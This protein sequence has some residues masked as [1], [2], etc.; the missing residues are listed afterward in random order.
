M[1]RLPAAIGIAAALAASAAALAASRPALAWTAFA[2]AFL[3]FGLSS[4]VSLNWQILAGTLLGIGFGHA[5]AD[6]WL[7]PETA[8]AMK[9]VGKLFIGLLKMLIA[10]MILLSISH[11]VASMEGA[12]ELGRLGSRTVLLYLATMVLAA[13]TGLVLVNAV[14]PGVGSDLANT[15][16][17]QQAV[18]SHSAPPQGPPSLGDFFFTTL[19]EVLQTPV[20]ALAEGRILPVVVFAILFGVALLQVGPSARP[21][22]DW[23]GGATAAVMKIIGWFVRLAPV[24]ILALIGHLVATVGFRVIVDNLAAF[25]AVVIGAT[26]FHSFVTLPAMCWFL[27]G[28]GPIELVRGLREALVVAFTTSSSAA[29]LPV[30][31]RCVEENLGVPRQIASFVLP[32]GATVNSDGTA[33][34]EA[35]AAVFV[36]SLYGIHLGLGGQIVVF[37]IAIAT[38]IGAPGIP[39]AGMVTMIVVLEAVGLPAE[40]VGLLLTIDRFLDTFR[41]VANVE[42]DAIVAVIVA[43]QEAGS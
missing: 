5:V 21:V 19:T 36:A 33:L 35:V 40:S 23:L 34:Y 16:F 22:V 32:L 20:A 4:R 14:Q 17:F 9:N 42:G 2:A 25:S 41:T 15:A 28:M 26:V 12:R 29:T 8:D 24:G 10:P 1:P 11:G 43:R 37:I 7:A 38:A 6:G 13:V 3:V 31:Q 18:G 39:S 27:G 30:S